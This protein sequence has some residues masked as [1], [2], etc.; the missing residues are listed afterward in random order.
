[1][2]STEQGRRKYDE[3]A[4][5]YEEIFFY[6]AD[7]GRQLSD[8]ANPAPGS[9]VLDVGAG[10]GAVA[11]AA[12]S[13]GCQVTAVDAS[14]GM[15]AHLAADHPEITA[16]QMDAAALNFPDHSFDLVTAGFVIQI[17]NDPIQALT[18]FRRVLTPGGTLA[19]SLETQSPDDLPWLADL[20]ADF[21]GRPRRAPSGP[22][23]ETHLNTLIE[24]AGFTN[25]THQPV[26]IPLPM[27]T[28]SA[29]WDWL[30]PRGLADAVAKLPPLRATEFHTRFLAAADSLQTPTGI[31]LTFAAT[32][33]RAQAPR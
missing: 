6:V 5:N 28:P 8:V 20:A 26:V 17:L 15:V 31:H 1:V 21:F 13:R 19:L 24:Q 7:V 22:M 30:A 29:L 23:T 3:I 32:L 33:H 9:R 18:E 25:L 2:T 10:R 12:L 27:P 14:P 11:R 4:A 16:R